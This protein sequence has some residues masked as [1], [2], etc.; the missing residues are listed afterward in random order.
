M[1]KREY[2][3]TLLLDLPEDYESAEKSLFE[4]GCDDA[5]VGVRY[6]CIF[7]DFCRAGDTLAD[8]IFSGMED[9]SKAGLC[10]RRVDSCEFVSQSEIASRIKYSRQAVSLYVKGERG[11][12]NFPPP[13]CHIDDDHAPLWNWCEVAQWFHANQVI[14]HS[15]LIDAMIVDL[16][17]N[18]LDI[19]RQQLLEPDLSRDISDRLGKF[20]C[21]CRPKLASTV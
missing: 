11:P 20:N 3:F 4:S 19:R 1:N 5:L 10:V 16:I 6:G 2:E 14:D 7:V 12:G 8:A 9:I 17:N 18:F 21:G 15:V 13:I